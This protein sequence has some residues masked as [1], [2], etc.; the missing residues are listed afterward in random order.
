[1]FSICCYVALLKLIMQEPCY[2]YF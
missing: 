1:M 2:E